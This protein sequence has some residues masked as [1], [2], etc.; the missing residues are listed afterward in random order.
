MLYV[1]LVFVALMSS[2]LP[3]FMLL[4]LLKTFLNLE[5]FF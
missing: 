3:T 2:Q 1:V 5:K 4:S